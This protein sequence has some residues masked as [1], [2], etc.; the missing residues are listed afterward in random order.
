MWTVCVLKL[1]AHSPPLY[2]EKKRRKNVPFFIVIDFP[3]SVDMSRLLHRTSCASSFFKRYF[4]FFDKDNARRDVAYKTNIPFRFVQNMSK[5]IYLLYKKK[6]N[7]MPF[8]LNIV[9]WLLTKMDCLSGIITFSGKWILLPILFQTSFGLVAMFWSFD[10]LS[11]RISQLY[12][13]ARFILTLHWQ[14]TLSKAIFVPIACYCFSHLT[15]SRRDSLSMC[16]VVLFFFISSCILSVHI[17]KFG[18]VYL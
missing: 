8:H 17:F 7:E 1:R 6:R 3:F 12:P 2:F 5:W 4:F 14:Y 10:S 9:T 16:C 13:C 11:H 18:F 15:V